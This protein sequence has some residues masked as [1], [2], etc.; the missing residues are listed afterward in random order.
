ME[1]REYN[2][3]IYQRSGP[4]EDWIA[5]GPSSQGGG[6]RVIPKAID[7]TANYQVPLAQAQ[8]GSA[9]ARAA[10][11]AAQAPYASQTAQAQAAK[12]L[13]DAQA[14]RV[15]ADKAQREAAIEK[16]AVSPQAAR[17][18]ADLSQNELL[19]A[20]ADARRT[21]TE[22]PNTAA[23]F[24]GNALG[25]V[26]G[27]ASSD[28]EGSLTTIGSR[29]VLDN[30]ARMKAQSQTGASGMG[31]LS[32]REG[33]Y[34]RDSIA[35]LKQSQSPGKLLDSLAQTE[36]HYRNMYAMA[37][38]EDPRNPE[39]AQKY[40]I[41]TLPTTG[42]GGQ[43]AFAQGANRE[44]ADPALAGV[45]NRIRGMIG[46]GKS[47]AEIS[48]YMNSVQPGLGDQRAA[49]VSAAVK[50]RA[51]N[52]RTPISQY[53]VSVENRSVPMSPLRQTV[54]DYAQSPFGAY[55][56]SAGD[57]I[58]AGTLDNMTSNPALARAGMATASRE[59]NI[60]SPLGSLTG[61][62]LAAMVGEGA[63]S[64]LGRLAPMAGDALYG[65][66]YGAGST[67]EGNRFTGAITGAGA[68]LGGGILGRAA[69]RGAGGALRGIRDEGVQMLNNAGVPMTV[70]QMASQS[71]RFGRYLKGREDRLS[72]YSGIGDKIKSRQTESLRGFNRAA[73]DEG[74]DPIAGTLPAGRGQTV[75]GEQGVADMRGMV[76]DRGG[77]YDQA[78]D[79]V[80]LT[81][82]AQFTQDMGAALAQGASIPRVG[83]EF[84][85]F[86]D[87]RIA[88][89]FDSP[90]GTISGRQMQDAIQ[91]IRG[92]DFGTDAMGGL[93][94]DAS[95]GVEGAIT[96][97]AGRQAPDAMPAFGNAN[98]AYR[99]LNILADAVGRGINTDG[100]FTPAQL[101]TAARGNTTRF[102]GKIAAA[103][104]D[105]PFYDLQRAA[106]N[107]LPSKVPDSG[108]AGRVAAD[109][110]LTST[111]RA[112]A[113]NLVNAPAYSEALQPILQLGLLN[114]SDRA[115][116][117]GDL[118]RRRARVGGLFGAPMLL[119]NGPF[120][121]TEGY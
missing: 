64:G 44:E 63:V 101:G 10:E 105:R 12:A 31:A 117:A 97:M 52:P 15:A 66:A 45:N 91:G 27:T 62:A 25:K 115:V 104:P 50:F 113:R 20:I 11:A 76:S 22:N 42:E 8:L 114:R 75:I 40:G 106:Q 81:P 96:D 58:T 55:A 72:G 83:P 54:N 61:G 69:M 80:S 102:G 38:G 121:V 67:D 99:N 2:G 89:H 33:A 84:T 93:A 71:G 77:A 87:Q 5:V 49:D 34:L 85:G 88:P 57:A 23:G 18:Q 60:A 82:D 17:M 46:A 92:A 37:N 1:T 65:A 39:I 28:L 95:R 90:D 13:A 30:L 100:I 9:Q 19:N 16:P 6:G 4:N 116:A 108:T 110:G 70:G 73:F 3:F 119:Q 120:A 7:P 35:S 79:G 86:V 41:A 59:H 36:R 103:T 29:N 112:G 56:M 94:S 24:L 26:G 47:A 78:L 118:L 109:G 111:L 32:E 107:I 98:T 53:A 48:A 21:I 51:Q 14:A 68:G 43:M 74:V